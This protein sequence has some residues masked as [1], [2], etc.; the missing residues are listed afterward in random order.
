MKRETNETLYRS[1]S[2]STSVKCSS[3]LPVSDRK[4]SIQLH[5]RFVLTSLFM[6]E[7]V[8]T[9]HRKRERERERE[10]VP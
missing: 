1:S 7:I 2:L 9:I 4:K 6:V 5:G 10:R 8:N 3:R